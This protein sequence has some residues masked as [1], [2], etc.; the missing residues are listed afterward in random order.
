MPVKKSAVLVG[1]L[2]GASIAVAAIAGAGMTLPQAGSGPHGGTLF[3]AST[4]PIFAPAPL[5]LMEKRICTACHIENLQP[6]GAYRARC[7]PGWH[8]GH[9]RLPRGIALRQRG[10]LGREFTQ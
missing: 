4:A 1:A 6:C 7:Y 3:H 9:R 8:T 10:Q 5:P 2:A